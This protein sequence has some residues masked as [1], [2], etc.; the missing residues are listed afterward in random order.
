MNQVQ[1]LRSDMFHEM[2]TGVRSTCHLLK[3]VKESDWSYRPADRMRSLKELASHLAA[4]PEADLAIMQEKEEDVIAR[5][6]KKY[7]ALQS[8]DEMAE[9]MQKGFDTF[10]TYMVSLSDEEFLT[11]K[12]KPFYLDEGMTQS[13]WLTETLTHVF[14]HRA[15]LFNYLKQL[16]YDVNM[17]D[18]YL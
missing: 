14:H 15:Q 2:E 3:K 1:A 9:A 8:A 4:I 16:G 13:R 11:K 12:T 17:F 18:L 5:I 6:E 10:K 7:G